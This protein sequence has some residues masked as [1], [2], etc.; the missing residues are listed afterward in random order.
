VRDAEI[1]PAGIGG[2]VVDPVGCDLAQFGDGEVMHPDRFGIA[3]GA[4][5]PTAILEVSDKLF[6][7]RINRY[8]WLPSRLERVDLRTD[9]FELRVAVGGS[10]KS[11]V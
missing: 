4:Q 8:G 1:D 9:V 6:L 2:D 10:G 7:F 11:L 3:F 5:F